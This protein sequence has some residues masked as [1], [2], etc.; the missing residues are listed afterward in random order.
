M[1][2]DAGKEWR[3]RRGG[4]RRWE[5]QIASLTQGAWIWANSRDSGGQ[6][7]SMLQSMGLQRVGHDF[8]TEQQQQQL[9]FID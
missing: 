7:P 2:P 9:G 3:Q 4:S 8:A 1:D 6:D 5:G